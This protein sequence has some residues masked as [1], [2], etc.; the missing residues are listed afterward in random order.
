MFITTATAI[1]SLGHGLH[2]LTA[3]SMLT[4]PSTFRGTV[5]WV[6]ALGL[7]NNKMTIMD[8]NGSCLSADSQSKL[9]GLV[10]RLAATL[11]LSLH[12]SNEPGELSP[13]LCHDDST[14]NIVLVIIIIIIYYTKSYILEIWWKELGLGGTRRLVT[15]T[16][17]TPSPAVL[18]AGFRSSF[19]DSYFVCYSMCCYAVWQAEY[20]RLS[21]KQEADR[22][23]AVAQCRDEMTRLLAASD[24]SKVPIDEELIRQKYSKETKQIKVGVV[25]CLISS[26]SLRGFWRWFLS[27]TSRSKVVSIQWRTQTRTEFLRQPRPLR[28]TKSLV[29]HQ[30]RQSYTL[31]YEPMNQQNVNLTVLQE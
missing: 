5:K 26:L 8:V 16:G 17:L 30:K 4:Q 23:N 28:L 2:T 22:L 31:I 27:G 18:K 13:W 7:N 9:V 11:A 12:S 20:E 1:C 24:V 29:T 10:W 25:Y 3:V 19:S 21:V 15:L 14:I 6:S